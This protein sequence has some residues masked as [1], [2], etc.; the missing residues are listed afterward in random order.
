MEQR[1]GGEPEYIPLT[2]AQNLQRAKAQKE[3]QEKNQAI[4]ELLRELY[5]PKVSKQ[6]VNKNLIKLLMGGIYIFPKRAITPSVLKYSP[7][8]CAASCR[9]R[10]PPAPPPPGGRSPPATPQSIPKTVY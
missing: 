8:R 10:R 2:H 4:G 3:T 5:Y 1:R 9:L 7:A 6:W